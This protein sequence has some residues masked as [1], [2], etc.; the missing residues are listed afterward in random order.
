MLISKM[1]KY[2]SFN[3]QCTLVALLVAS[4]CHLYSLLKIAESSINDLLPEVS[5]YTPES[6]MKQQKLIECVLMGSNKQ[7]LGKAYTEERVYELTVK[8]VN[9]LFSNY[10]VK[11]SGQMVKSLSKSI[12]RMYSMGACAV[13]G[14]SNQ[15]MLSEDLE[16]EPFLDFSLQRFMC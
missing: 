3:L 4:T 6:D 15:G 8:E 10:E 14:M 2:V 5:Y 11:L 1:I 7:F 13:L 12:I 9:K 16:S